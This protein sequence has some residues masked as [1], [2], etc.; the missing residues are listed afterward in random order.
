MRTATPASELHDDAI[1]VDGHND[2][3][4]TIAYQR[5]RGDIDHFGDY[6]LPLMRRGGVDVQITPVFI[7]DDHRPEGALRRTLKLIELLHE[8]VASHSHEATVCTTAAQIE[9]AVNSQ[10]IAFVPAL[11]GCEA[12]YTDVELLRSMYRLG[13]RAASLTHFGRTQL[14]DGSALED[15]GSGLTP[16]GREAVEEMQRLGIVVDVSHLSAQGTDDI[17]AMAT[18]PIIATHS[19]CRHLRDHHRNLR[20]DHLR[21]IAHSGGVVGINFFPDFIDPEDF[22]IDRLIDHIEHALEVAGEDHVGLGP[23]F[24]RE[25]FCMVGEL[26]GGV[27]ASGVRLTQTIDGLE[28]IGQLPNLTAAMLQRGFDEETIRKV[29]GGNFLR[30]L[31]E[32]LIDDEVVVNERPAPISAA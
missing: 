17:L 22:S 21:G 13:I 12:L 4:L 15:G 23:D 31:R 19:S 28:T 3:L 18:G 30:V 27:T 26:D 2:L 24:V 25:Y 10:R 9:A 16:A 20:D 14:G 6:W 7:E 5:A 32:V 8:V 1:V 29:L 11:E